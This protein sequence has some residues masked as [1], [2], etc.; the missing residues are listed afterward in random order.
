MNL[1]V[2]QALNPTFPFIL[3]RGTNECIFRLCPILCDFHFRIV[4]SFPIVQFWEDTPGEFLKFEEHDNE[5]ERFMAHD[6]NT[7]AQTFA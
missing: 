6:L 7:S 1:S 2:N 3:A 5:I 4:R